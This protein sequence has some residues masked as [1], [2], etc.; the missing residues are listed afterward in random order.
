MCL[1]LSNCGDTTARDIGRLGGGGEEAEEAMVAL[2]LVD[3]SAV[4]PLLQAL[5][6]RDSDVSV[7]GSVAEI[8][9]HIYQRDGNA[10][11]LAALMEEMRRSEGLLRRRLVRVLG[12]LGQERLAGALIDLL[13]EDKDE[14]VRLEILLALE[15]LTGEMRGGIF[16]EINSHNLAATDRE[17]LAKTLVRLAP[18]VRTDSLQSKFSDWLEILANDK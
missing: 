12:H 14:G 18:T 4:E 8:L 10:H 1:S 15:N 5:S 16:L 2:S 9:S 3:G 6:D 11:I 17:R 13:E 7:R